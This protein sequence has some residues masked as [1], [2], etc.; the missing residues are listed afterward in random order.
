[1]VKWLA[2]PLRAAYLAAADDVIEQYR[3][4]SNPSHDDFDWQKARLCLRRA[5]ELGG[6]DPT[7][8]GK[9]ALCNGYIALHAKPPTAQAAL[10]AKASFDEAASYLPRSPDPH[11]GLAR[12]Y[13]Y[14]LRNLG[15]AAAELSLAER[16]GFRAGPREAEQQADGYLFR[17][18]LELEQAA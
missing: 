9:V 11:L 4:S 1:P 16:F 8:K 6:S 18:E 7:V 12:V 2:A 15:R 17:A 13:I 14:N 10:Q 5:A 3:N